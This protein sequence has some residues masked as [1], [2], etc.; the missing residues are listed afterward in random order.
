VDKSESVRF[1]QTYPQLVMSPYNRQAPG[2][3]NGAE[4]AALPG[5][6]SVV[7]KDGSESPA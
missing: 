6:A 5:R 3:E 7:N 2:E 1:A 4:Q